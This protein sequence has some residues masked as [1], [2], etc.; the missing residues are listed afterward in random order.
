MSILG[1]GMKS[2]QRHCGHTVFRA[3]KQ[4][5]FTL[6]PGVWKGG[7]ITMGDYGRFETRI[8]FQNDLTVEEYV[9]LMND[10]IES[11]AQTLVT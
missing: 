5:N 2:Y 4:Q 3:T 8:E 6:S 1:I 7:C 11:Q 9:A 10:N